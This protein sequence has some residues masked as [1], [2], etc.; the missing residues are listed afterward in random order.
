MFRTESEQLRLKC[1]SGEVVEFC[2]EAHGHFELVNGVF[3]VIQKMDHGWNVVH[4]DNIRSYSLCS[5]VDE[6]SSIPILLV[7]GTSVQVVHH[8]RSCNMHNQTVNT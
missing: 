4:I 3:Q 2:S 8:K 1:A 6:I 5:S 7:V